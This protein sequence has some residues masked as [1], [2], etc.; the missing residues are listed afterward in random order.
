MKEE[1]LCK[2]SYFKRHEGMGYFGKVVNLLTSVWSPVV[3]ATYPLPESDAKHEEELQLEP[4]PEP[5]PPHHS[6]DWLYDSS[7]ELEPP[8]ILYGSRSDMNSFIKR[9]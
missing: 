4:D 5:V 2:Q 7:P 8:P 3:C 6:S 1:S 9:A